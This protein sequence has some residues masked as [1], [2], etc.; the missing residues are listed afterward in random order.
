MYLALPQFPF[1]FMDL[2]VRTRMAP[3]ALAPAIRQAVWSVDTI[4]WTV[5]KCTTGAASV[6]GS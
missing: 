5:R 1:S 3:E 4:C 6:C 2:V